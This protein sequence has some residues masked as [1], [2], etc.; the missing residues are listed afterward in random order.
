MRLFG[1]LL[2]LEFLETIKF[3][4][5]TFYR[6]SRFRIIIRV[7]KPNSIEIMSWFNISKAEPKEIVE[8]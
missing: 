2:N 4:G 3:I 5:Y 7:I 1:Y 6:Y 8:K